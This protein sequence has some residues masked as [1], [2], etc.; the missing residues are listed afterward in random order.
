MQKTIK[1]GLIL[2]LFV[3]MF[4]GIVVVG[5]SGCTSK[6][7]LAA[8]QAAA[9]RLDLSEAAK[10]HLLIVI[11]DDGSMALA[12]KEDIVSEI[13][14]MNISDPEVEELIAKA[15]KIVADLRKEEVMISEQVQKHEHERME[16]ERKYEK[17]EEYFDAVASSRSTEMTDSYIN[18]AL[19][20]FASPDVP[21]LIIVHMEGSLKD[22]G[23][24]TTI[25]RCL[26]Y[27]KDQGR[28]MNEIYNVVFDQNGKI[29]E[30]ELIKK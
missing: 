17:I 26:E 22:Y 11:N 24:P 8:Q 19:K 29:T 18:D 6:K 2:K 15:E 4:A 14:G 21:V 20:F 9:E 16:M 13:K 10:Q 1:K 28:N 25:K 23:R 30:L 3:L 7:K 27:L 5:F 12:E